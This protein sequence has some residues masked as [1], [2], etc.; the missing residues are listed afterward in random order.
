[1]NVE[2]VMRTEDM[3][4]LTVS[5][6]NI[7][8]YATPVLKQLYILKTLE[9]SSQQRHVEYEMQKKWIW[10]SMNERVSSAARTVD[11][12]HKER[13]SFIIHVHFCCSR[14]TLLWNVYNFNLVLIWFIT[15]R[16]K[17]HVWYF[18]FR[19]FPLSLFCCPI[20]PAVRD[21]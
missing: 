18:G 5:L 14:D 21:S 7:S 12:I 15:R 2:W 20:F 11:C 13:K 19:F 1:M 16:F 10:D 4:R 6:K 9:N 3:Q 17:F 8:I